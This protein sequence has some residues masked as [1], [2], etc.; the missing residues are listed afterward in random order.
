M[1]DF[2]PQSIDPAAPQPPRARPVAHALLTG[3]L[4][5]LLLFVGLFFWC[6]AV[7]QSGEYMG[8]QNDEVISGVVK[9][10]LTELIWLEVRIL[11]LYAAIGL[12]AGTLARGVLALWYTA[13]GRPQPSRGR[14]AILVLALLLTMHASLLARS[15]VRTPQVMAPAYADRGGFGGWLQVTL[16]DTVSL[17]ALDALAWTALAAI[18]ALAL[19][20]L[21]R[22]RTSLQAFVRASPWLYGAVAL[23]GVLAALPF[24]M[25]RPAPPLTA[26]NVVILAVDSMRPD[27]I[28]QP[29]ERALPELRAF[30]EQSVAFSNAWTVI[31]RTFPSWVSILTARY[32]Q[33]HG[34]RHMFPTPEVLATPRESL[35]SALRR[36]GYRTGVVSDFAG[37]I[38][39][40]ID[41]GFESVRVPRFTLWSNVA[42][43]G[44]KL[45][46]H[47][48][49]YLL[50]ILGGPRRFPTLKLW[51]RLADPESLTEE[52]LDFLAAGASDTEGPNG[53]PRPFALVVFYSAA[54]FPYAS[55]YP[56]YKRFTDPSYAGPSRYNKTA[57]VDSS[58][59]PGADEQR[60]IVALYD[61]AL[62]ATDR[63]MGRLLRN[64]SEHG[65]LER[66]HVVVTADHG[67]NLYER[68]LGVGHGDHLRGSESLRIPL[69]LRPA[70]F[71]PVRR[72][73]PNAVRSIDIVPTLLDYVG[74]PELPGQSG[75]SLKPLVDAAASTRT[76]GAPERRG[77]HASDDPPIFFET[78]L[79][80]I[81]PEAEVLN[82]RQLRF[83]KG[84][85]AFRTTEDTHEIY[86]D[87]KYD[88]MLLVAKHRA[89][90]DDGYKLI[91]VPLRK[92]VSFELYDVET[93]PNETTDLVGTRP[94]VARELQRTLRDFL[95]SDPTMI[96][97]GDWVVPRPDL[98]P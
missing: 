8:V 23:A 54:H 45:H 14:A 76:S 71:H 20:S 63:A 38:F 18:V 93:D 85:E 6:F 39:S 92:G 94:D 22:H 7:M 27:R 31:A 24:A 96:E 2:E 88:R 29:G 40:R 50:E 89:V 47:L 66:S 15:M 46:H 17:A 44:W 74:L 62:H 75:R 11:G 80:F 65:L 56:D 61:G 98:A 16:T 78:E 30:A 95:L 25:R 42:L 26:N 59:A 1:S 35:I 3:P 13:R 33:E 21:V 90:L 91:Y 4:V 53:E 73:V 83:S 69:L 87:P 86:H 57:W 49:P 28:E 10:F 32:P 19:M 84:F 52:A 60:Q 5:G 51:E 68:G 43:G 67:E 37:D 48:L 9:Q 72:V 97:Q 77:A 82:G 55:P 58:T 79:W 70:T 41:L 12:V 34:I 36:A 81:N 64:L